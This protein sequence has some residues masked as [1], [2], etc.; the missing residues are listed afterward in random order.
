MIKV[1]KE[2]NINPNVTE[3]EI[4]EDYLKLI[5]DFVKLHV[6]HLKIKNINAKN[7]NPWR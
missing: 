5:Y 4:K 2:N 6:Q 7:E 3:E 1:I